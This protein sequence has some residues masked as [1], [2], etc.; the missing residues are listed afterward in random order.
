MKK[1]FEIVGNSSDE[2]KQTP[3]ELYA[4]ILVVELARKFYS[5]FLFAVFLYVVANLR[6]IL[7]QH[8]EVQGLRMI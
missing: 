7:L 6:N 5:M 4:G 1:L 3:I 8:S 2:P